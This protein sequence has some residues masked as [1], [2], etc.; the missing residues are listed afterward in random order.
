MALREIRL[1]VGARPINWGIVWGYPD[2]LD[3]LYTVPTYGMAVTGK[4]DDGKPCW[5]QFEVIRFAVYHKKGTD[6]FVVGLQDQQSYDIQGWMAYEMHS[7][8]RGENGAWR[9]T[10]NFLVH[11]GPD[12]PRDLSTGMFGSAGCI[13]ICGWRGFSR[14]NDLLIRLSGARGATREEKLK[15]IGRGRRLKITYQAADR[16]PLKLRGRLKPSRP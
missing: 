7:T 8:D 2:Y 10:G 14:L 6:P 3:E 11:D 15:Q 13:E 4:F 9:V 1:I 16:P 5:K 12:D